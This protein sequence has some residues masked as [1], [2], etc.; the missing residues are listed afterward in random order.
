V[1]VTPLPVVRAG[2]LE[3]QAPGERWLIQALWTRA[4]VGI[5]SG[6]P[7]SCKSWLVLEM[8]TCV[9]AGVPCLGR[10][11]V[12]DSG[13]TLVYLAEDALPQVR[14]RIASLCA[15][16]RLDIESLELHVITAPS[17][18][19]DL[20]QDQQRLEATVARLRPRLLV[21]DPLVRMHRLDENSASDVSGL[22]GYLR[23]LQRA[24]D[25]AIALVHH[26]SKKR[27]GQAGLSLRGSSDLWAFT[28]SGAY[29]V[30]RDEDVLLTC[31]HRST[32]APRPMTL[33]LMSA[34]DGA[35]LE[36]VDGPGAA[37]EQSLSARVLAA[38]R[39]RERPL[40]RE[41]L[42]EALRVNTQRLGEVLAE[43]EKRD[44]ITRGAAGWSVRLPT[45]DDASA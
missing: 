27:H 7:K 1:A 23:E 25:V 42:R 13:P 39:E 45:R 16:H 36:L 33:R 9:A 24:H 40:T 20:P 6:A 19:L 4:A 22:L 28:D 2:E 17:L 41:A 8:A 26:S 10:F 43:L 30:R 29:L 32:Q 15:H 21:L 38:L 11:R 35:H 14:E 37:I 3:V 31:E 34:G 44:H 12:D 18:R 5:V